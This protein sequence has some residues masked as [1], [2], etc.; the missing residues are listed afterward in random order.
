MAEGEGTTFENPSYEPD[1]W[2]DDDDYGDETT[3]FMPGEAST[4][5]FSQY[6][7]RIREEI[8]MMTMQEDKGPDTSYTETS[9]GAQTSSERAWIAAKDLFPK[10]SSSEL[11]VSYNTKG[12]LQV[13]MFGAGKKTYNLMTTERGTGREQINKSLQKEIQNALG[14]TKYEIEREDFKKMMDERTQEIEKENKNLKALEESDDPPQSEI[15]KIK[16]KIQVLQIEKESLKSEY[17]LADLRISAASQKEIE[18]QQ[19]QVRNFASEFTMARGAYNRRYPSDKY[20]PKTQY[21]EVPDDEESEIFDERERIKSIIK[22]NEALRARIKSDMF[23]SENQEK[24]PEIRESAKKRLEKNQATYEKNEEEKKELLDR[25][26]IK[27]SVLEKE[28]EV[29][30]KEK[31]DLDM[32]IEGDKKIIGDLNSTAY[33]RE[34]AEA[35]IEQ[36]E[37]EREWVSARL[38]QTERNL[39]LEDRRSLREKIKE[40]FKKNGVTVT[41]IFLA[42]GATIGAVI[43]TLTN[44]LKKLGKGLANGLK[45]VGEK[46]ASALPGLIGAVASFLFK[47]AASVI[48][49]LADVALDSGSGRISFPKIDEKELARCKKQQG[50]DSNNANNYRGF[51]D[52]MLWR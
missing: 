39:G 21:E 6:Q 33:E 52:F 23:I 42:A 7:A 37:R 50:N 22:Q 11:E 27:K 40:I 31:E 44:A 12:R 34:A 2:D 30:Q 17:T 3:P 20:E 9:F 13:K 48:G 49:F 14:E 5:A 18:K 47:A 25:L 32:L 41:A 10:M 43:G 24:T 19:G 4:P 29:F 45:K 46:A 8:E 28:R 51:V 35:R 16:A 15:D 1:P 26:G 38:E 36:R